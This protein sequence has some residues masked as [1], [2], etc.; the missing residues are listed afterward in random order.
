MPRSCPSRR[1][2]PTATATRNAS[3]K[4]SRTP[5]WDHGARIAGTFSRAVPVFAV[6]EASRPMRNPKGRC[7]WPPAATTAACWALKQGE[8][9]AAYPTVMAVGRA[10][11]KTATLETVEST[12]DPRSMSDRASSVYTTALGGGYTQ[13][14]GTSMAAPQAWPRPGGDAGPCIPAISRMPVLR[15]LRQSTKDIGNPEFDNAAVR[16]TAEW[17][18]RYGGRCTPAAAVSSWNR[19]SGSCRRQ[20][21]FRSARRSPPTGGSRRF[22]LVSIEAPY[23]GD[24]RDSGPEPAGRRR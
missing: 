23:D 15:L 20:S 19:T 3:A 5:C 13:E 4:P 24:G 11:A 12:R 7:S 17:T 9:S 6:F 22:G 16:A 14:E 10:T 1:W 18:G 8:Y 21:C 2:T